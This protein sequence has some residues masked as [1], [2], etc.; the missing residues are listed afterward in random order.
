MELAAI[1]CS[2]G[3]IRRLKRGRKVLSSSA[4]G[5]V[6]VQSARGT[7]IPQ[8]SALLNNVNSDVARRIKNLYVVPSP[9]V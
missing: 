6:R 9:V 3:K 7:F 4:I 5:H 1:N 2:A 8:Q